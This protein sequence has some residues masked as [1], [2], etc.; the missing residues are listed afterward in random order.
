MPVPKETAQGWWV[1]E[2]V[3]E[4]N[5]ENPTGYQL[6]LINVPEGQEMPAQLVVVEVRQLDEEEDGLPVVEKTIHQYFDANLL[7]MKMTV[8]E[9]DRV[10]ECIGL[11]PLAAAIEKGQ[12]I[13]DNIR[14]KVEKD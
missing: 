12:K 1:P 8:E 9:Y 2:I 5:D 11:E 3:Y 13:T 10:R 7:K 14:K 6:P 4:E